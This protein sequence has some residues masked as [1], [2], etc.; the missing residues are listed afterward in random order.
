MWAEKQHEQPL[1]WAE[2]QQLT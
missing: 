2:K 1:M